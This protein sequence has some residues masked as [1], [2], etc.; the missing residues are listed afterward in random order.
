MHDKSTQ[1]SF[2]QVYKTAIDGLGKSIKVYKMANK[3]SHG[4]PREKHNIYLFP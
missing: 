4:R 2:L 3:E 1:K